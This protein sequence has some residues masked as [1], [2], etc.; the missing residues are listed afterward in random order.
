MSNSPCCFAIG[1]A[2]RCSCRPRLEDIR[3]TKVPRNSAGPRAVFW[4]SSFPDAPKRRAKCALQGEACDGYS[5]EDGVE[6][7]ERPIVAQP[8]AFHEGLGLACGSIRP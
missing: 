5:G 6:V 8:R 3:S 2:M 1:T 4:A 7:N